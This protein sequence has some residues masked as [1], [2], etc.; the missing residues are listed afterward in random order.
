MLQPGNF[1]AG[2][3]QKLECRSFSMKQKLLVK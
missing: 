1:I 2:Q 3:I